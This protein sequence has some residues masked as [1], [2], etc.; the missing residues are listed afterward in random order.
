MT[1]TM[2]CS[3]TL[4][5]DAPSFCEKERAEVG[6]LDFRQIKAVHQRATRHHVVRNVRHGTEVRHVHIS[7]A[8]DRP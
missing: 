2:T 5:P 4:S 1:S 6:H 3:F 7:A 8:D